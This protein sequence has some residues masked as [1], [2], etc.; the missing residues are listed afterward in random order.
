MTDATRD[1]LE[2]HFDTAFAAPDGIKKLRELILTLAMQGKLVEQD[3]TDQPAS[4]L[5]KEIDAEKQRLVKAGKIKAPKPLPPIKPEEVPYQL[6]QGW[7]WVR[8][9]EIGIIN[10]RNDADDLAKAGFVPM[11]MIPEGYSEK[12]QFEERSWSEIKKG[13]T[14]FADGD[15]GMAKITPCFE[16]GKSCVFSGLPNGI[17]AGTTELHIFRNSFNSVE[18]RFLLWYLKN[19]HYISKAVPKMTGS[20]GQKRVPTPYFT[21][22]PFPLPP[23]S[24][25][26]RIVA[27]I[28]QL[29]ARCDVLETLRKEREEKRQAVHAAAIQQ[30]LSAPSG[31]AWDFI[32]QH[33]GALYTVKENVAELRKAI[34]QLAVMGRLVPQDPK[35][36]P[37][38]ELLKEIDAEKQRLVKAGKIKAPKPLP[39]INPKDVPYELPQ[40]WEWVRF[41]NIAFQITDGAHHTPTYMDQGIPFLSV[42]DMSSGSLDFSDTR[43]ISPRQHQELIRRCHPKKGD[44]LLTKVGTTGIPILVDVDCE[45][46]IFVSVALIKF[47]HNLIDG[48][49]LS[50]LIKAPSVKKQSEEGTEGV[51]NKNLVLRKIANFL[52]AL[53]PLPEQRR[54]V[55]RIDQLMALCDALEQNISDATDKQTELL[56]AVMAQV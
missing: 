55:A 45:F 35:A 6:P 40:G 47:P 1:L 3:P 39:P 24:E 41:G 52:L 53:P 22:Q 4:E 54:I 44:L 37:A 46:S 42:K 14:H 51:G 11:P 48:K 16:N 33:F 30:L 26:H 12:H 18:P 8:L 31:S 15:I 29:M 19:P 2:Q 7:E 21:E 56:H 50:W 25:Q 34:L 5:L 28:E 9:G 20:A 38:G 10:P 23:L 43:Y 13:Y 27:R 17:G 36:P 49:Y 32:Q